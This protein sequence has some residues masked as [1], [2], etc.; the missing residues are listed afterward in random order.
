MKSLLFNINLIII[1]F[2]LS[3]C[4]FQTSIF[5][6]MNKNLIKENLIISPISIY[7]ILS[8]TANG[9]KGNTFKQ[10]LTALSDNDINNLNKI[11]LG[12][13][14]AVKQFSSVEIANAI[15]TTFKPVNK[16]TNMAYTYEATI[17]G[18]RSAAQINEWC[19]KKT[20]GKITEV[21]KDIDPLTRIIL[22]NAVY[23]KG[24]WQKQ[25]NQTLTQKSD[26][27]NF[28][29]KSQA[30]KVDMMNIEEKFNYYQ[31]SNVQIIELPFNKDS[32]STFI[33]LPP[34]NSNINDFISN[35]DDEK[36]KKY[37]DQMR[38]LKVKLF[39]PK[40]ELEFGSSLNKVLKQLGMVEAFSPSADFTGM[41][42]DG[43]IYIEKVIHKTYLKV[44]ENG[45]EAA[46]VTA[47]KMKTWTSL[48]EL[49]MNVNKPFLMLIKSKE[50]QE[51]NDFLF[52][53]KIEDILG[54]NK[55]KQQ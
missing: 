42:R 25:F 43:G 18:L 16:F 15:F 5:Q 37:L 32:V 6:Q 17:Q 20:H 3:L 40:F 7:Q 2:S 52:M 41:N 50:L 9:A 33:F 44:D 29:D 1:C 8:L 39:L 48:P 19:S 55:L 36:I 35:L 45:A 53:A 12:I 31:D 51:N 21:I 30:V 11:N 10:M 47:V 23:F 13:L 27:Y 49:K 14:R 4:S 34:V 26:F 22:I 54:K 38:K 46:A 28:G 24:Q